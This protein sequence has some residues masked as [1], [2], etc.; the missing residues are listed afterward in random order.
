MMDSMRKAFS[1]EGNMEGAKA[2]GMEQSVRLNMIR[3]R[4][5][6]KAEA[7]AAARTT[8]M[9]TPLNTTEPS[10]TDEQLIEEFASVVPGGKKGGNNK[11]HS[12]K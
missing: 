4:L 6:R 7:N 11:K 12:K 5:R 2:A 3:E 9:N 1:F 10:Y 8:S